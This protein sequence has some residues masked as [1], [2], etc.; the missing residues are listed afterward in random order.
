M[1]FVELFQELRYLS[2]DVV[3]RSRSSMKSTNEQ[4]KYTEATKGVFF[5]LDEEHDRL[6]QI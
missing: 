2:H 3:S 4:E 5:L 6:L 1:L